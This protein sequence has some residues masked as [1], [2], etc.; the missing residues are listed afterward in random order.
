MEKLIAWTEIPTQDLERGVEFYNNLLEIKLQLT[1]SE[2]E[3]MA[4]FPTGEGALIKAPGFT[5]SAQ[6]VVVSFNVG[7]RLEELLEKVANWGGRIVHP[8]TKIE[9]EG[10]AYFALIIDSEGNRIG[11]YGE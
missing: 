6:G 2:N 4:C 7:N 1:T 9:A 8:K 11:L 5:P 10:R 3:S